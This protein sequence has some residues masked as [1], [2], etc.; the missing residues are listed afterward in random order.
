MI[1]RLDN[2][3]GLKP[4]TAEEQKNIKGGMCQVC[5]STTQCVNPSGCVVACNGNSS[6]RYCFWGTD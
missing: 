6:D 2:L 1:K 5:H 4:M 3:K